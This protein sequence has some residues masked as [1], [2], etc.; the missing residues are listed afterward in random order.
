MSSSS[1]SSSLFSVRLKENTAQIEERRKRLFEHYQQQRQDTAEL[2]E[3]ANSASSSEE[4]EFVQVG[5][6]ETP[7]P[8]FLAKPP[9]Q[10][11]FPS[12]VSVLFEMRPISRVVAAAWRWPYKEWPTHCSLCFSYSECGGEVSYQVFEVRYGDRLPY[13]GPPRWSDSARCSKCELCADTTLVTELWKSCY[14]MTSL[15]GDSG[16]VGY[17]T[18]KHYG[19][20]LPVLGHRV[21]SLWRALSRSPE[22]WT[23]VEL[24]VYVLSQYFDSIRLSSAVSAAEPAE[25]DDGTF[26]STPRRILDTSHFYHFMASSDAAEQV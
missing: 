8:E 15:A 5:L 13:M 26:F 3:A 14:R 9:P 6:D 10:P 19:A 25:N 7:L 23:P 22:E 11:M 4:E 1:S 2:E 12:G 24:V 16:G 20:Y 18:L 21:A 17:D